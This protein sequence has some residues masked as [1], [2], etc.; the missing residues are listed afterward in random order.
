MRGARKEE[1]GENYNL[2]NFDKAM[3]EVWSGTYWLHRQLRTGLVRYEKMKEWTSLH[4]KITKGWS[5][6]NNLDMSHRIMVC[7]QRV[8]GAFLMNGRASLEVWGSLMHVL[9]IPHKWNFILDYFSSRLSH[10]IISIIVAS[11]WRVSLVLSD[12]SI[13]I[14]YHSIRI[15]MYHNSNDASLRNVAFWRFLG[16]VDNCSLVLW[17]ACCLMF[18]VCR[19]WNV[20]CGFLNV[21]LGDP[22]N[23]KYGDPIN[24]KLMWDPRNR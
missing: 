24:F 6:A 9:R 14:Q 18:F 12:I 23:F 15:S 20:C 19:N 22:I 11:P 5:V 3:S 2:S 17:S 8:S 7:L 21:S 1:P 10:R 13:C 4:A 16:F